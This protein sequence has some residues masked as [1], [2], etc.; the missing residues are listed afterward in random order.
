MTGAEEWAVYE[1]RN[2]RANHQYW[3]DRCARC[4]NLPRWNFGHRY[5]WLC[6]SCQREE[7]RKI[8]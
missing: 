7:A 8:A 2:A 3:L 1:A 4:G 6:T 5:E